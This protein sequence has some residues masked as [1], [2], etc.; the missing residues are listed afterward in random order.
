VEPTL[1]DRLIQHIEELRHLLVEYELLDETQ[2]KA[3]RHQL[4]V[5]T[6]KFGKAIVPIFPQF[7]AAESE[8]INRNKS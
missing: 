4:Y 6:G 8:L 1:Q 7:K 2:Q 5:K 3:I